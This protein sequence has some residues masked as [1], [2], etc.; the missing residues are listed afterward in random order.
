MRRRVFITL[1]VARP[2][3]VALAETLDVLI[4]QKAA[5]EA[6][7]QILARHLDDLRRYAETGM[8]APS[9]PVAAPP[10]EAAKPSPPPSRRSTPEPIEAKLLKLM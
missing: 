9:E 6:V 8:F 7:K 3:D 10:R 5:S 2:R 4:R 1:S